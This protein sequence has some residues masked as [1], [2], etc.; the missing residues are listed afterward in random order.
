MSPLEVGVASYI[1]QT[2]F[3][4]ISRLARRGFTLGELCTMTTAGTALCLE[5]WRL[6]RARVRFSAPRV[7]G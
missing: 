1:Q 5:F 7:M 6:S 4:V 2:S 3:Y